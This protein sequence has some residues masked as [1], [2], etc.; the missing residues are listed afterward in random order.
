VQHAMIP[1][2][3]SKQPRAFSSRRPAAVRRTDERCSN[4]CP[5]C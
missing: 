1:Y 5:R 4:C 3:R 2:S